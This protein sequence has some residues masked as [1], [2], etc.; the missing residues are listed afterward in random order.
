MATGTSRTRLTKLDKD[1]LQLTNRH[2]KVMQLLTTLWAVESVPSLDTAYCVCCPPASPKQP[3]N[4]ASLQADAAADMECGPDNERVII[5]PLTTAPGPWRAGTAS[6]KQRRIQV[7]VSQSY[8]MIFFFLNTHIF[9][10]FM[11]KWGRWG[12]GGGESTN[13]DCPRSWR[14]FLK[15]FSSS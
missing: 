14:P 4:R 15:S 5:S 7:R 11:F 1:S 6:F 8:W 10:N 13:K 2:E 3:D 12:G 9:V